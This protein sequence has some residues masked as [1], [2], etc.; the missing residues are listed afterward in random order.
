MIS[1]VIVAVE[2]ET[3][4]G[5]GKV[6]AVAMIMRKEEKGFYDNLRAND[7]CRHV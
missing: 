6:G 4:D 3:D 1:L 7:C 5:E 2:E